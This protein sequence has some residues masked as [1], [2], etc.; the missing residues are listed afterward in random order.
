[1]EDAKTL[2]QTAKFPPYGRRGFGSPFS[3]GTFDIN[4]NLSGLEYMKN[5][6]DNLLTI[7]Q[8]ETKE[9]L[10]NVSMTAP[11]A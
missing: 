4:G 10:D 7:V 3:M 2:V 1:V 11:S 5:A 6:N 8:I 9:A